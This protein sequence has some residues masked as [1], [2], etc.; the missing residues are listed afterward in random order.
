ML[1][2]FFLFGQKNNKVIFDVALGYLKTLEEQI[3]VAEDLGILK[4][5][6]F[7]E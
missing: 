3:V 4:N 1:D 6:V 7:T 5:Q 2:L